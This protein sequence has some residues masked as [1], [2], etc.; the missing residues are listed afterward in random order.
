MAKKRPTV[1]IGCASEGLRIAQAI[2]YN[3]RDA[4]FPEIWNENIFQLSETTIEGLTRMAHTYDFA[5]LVFTAH[6]VTQSRKVTKRAPR[7]NVVFETGLFMGAL[8]PK[9]VFIVKPARADL[10]LPSDLLGLTSAEYNNPPAKSDRWESALGPACGQIEKAI[11]KEKTLSSAKAVAKSS[12]GELKNAAQYFN[13]M[14]VNRYGVSTAVSSV[15]LT[16]TD[17]KGSAVLRRGLQRIKVANKSGF[18]IER[19]P[20]MVAPGHPGGR[21]VTYPDFT[22]KVIFPK[23]VSL[24]PRM[25]KPN[26]KM[27]LFDIAIRGAL[28][29][30]DRG[31]SLEYESSISKF[32]AMTREE[33]FKVYKEVDFPSEYISLRME[34][35]TDKTILEV[36]FPDGYKPDINPG[37]FFGDSDSIHDA[38]L[39]RVRKGFQKSKRGARFVISKPLIGFNYRIYWNPPSQE[40]FTKITRGKL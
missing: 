36:V 11:R 37:V 19:I 39:S 25:K 31:L 24:I 5:V 3:L 18:Q 10:K 26:P 14:L 13:K 40:D 38:E 15:V 17:F 4:A 30:F 34:M 1:F 2:Q 32:C 33:F 8:E 6:D 16:I 28:T 23:K 35:P 29:Q 7:D 9:R 20:G 27:Y 21:I 22:K 12:E